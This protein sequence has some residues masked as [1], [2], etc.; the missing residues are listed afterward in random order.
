MLS[1]YLV[2]KPEIVFLLWLNLFMVSDLGIGGPRFDSEHPEH[3][4]QTKTVSS[5][6]HKDP[7]H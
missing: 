7:R 2:T 5:Q 4:I 3:Q 1:N 6:L